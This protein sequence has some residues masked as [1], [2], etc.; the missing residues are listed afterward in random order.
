[1]WGNLLHYRQLTKF[2]AITMLISCKIADIWITDL[3]YHQNEVI[4][5]KSTDSRA[6]DK[7]TSGRIISFSRIQSKHQLMWITNSV[8]LWQEVI[9]WRCFYAFSADFHVM[10][11][12]QLAAMCCSSCDT[13]QWQKAQV[14]PHN[15]LE[16]SETGVRVFDWL[17]AEWGNS[18]RVQ[19]IW[20]SPKQKPVSNLPWNHAPLKYF[21]LFFFLF[22][23]FF[24]S[25][26]PSN[27]LGDI[28][29]A[30]LVQMQKQWLVSELATTT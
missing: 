22:F 4:K 1:M 29:V 9:P 7:T 12:L 25:V 30:R 23:F 14:W 27:N 26:N 28:L 11:V 8:L 21:G 6:N 18:Y 19:R 16:I 20:Y 2:S 5:H 3:N 10:A 13:E 15:S 24:K 17:L